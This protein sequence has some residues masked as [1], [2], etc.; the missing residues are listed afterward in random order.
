[1]RSADRRRAA[2][3]KSCAFG[4]AFVAVPPGFV[5]D[6]QSGNNLKEDE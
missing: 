2:I 5:I 1:L 4:G 6:P 3:D